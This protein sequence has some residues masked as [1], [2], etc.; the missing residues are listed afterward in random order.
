MKRIAI[1]GGIGSG[2]TTFCTLLSEVGNAPI[3]D[4]DLRAKEL[5]NSHPLIRQ[6]I[7]E[8]FGPEAYSSK[9]LNRAYI[10]Q[11]AF[12]DS[13][14]LGALNQIVHPVVV[15]DFDRWAAEQ[16]SRYV[17]LESALLFSSPLRGHYDLSIVVDAPLEV[18]IERATRRDGASREQIEARMRNQ[19]SAEEMCRL[20]DRVVIADNIESLRKQAIELHN[21]ILGN[22]TTTAQ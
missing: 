2:K 7:I 16:E 20:A 14:Q 9:G 8:L 11:K 13:S 5:M 4:S 22:Q 17:I 18:R 15:A 12:G 1:T 3:Y 19:M 21:L 10:A 6:G